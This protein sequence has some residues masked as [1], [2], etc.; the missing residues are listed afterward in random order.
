MA[1]HILLVT[2]ACLLACASTHGM[3]TKR[4]LKLH[5]SFFK[6][7]KLGRKLPAWRPGD[8]NDL[9]ARFQYHYEARCFKPK[10][11]KLNNEIEVAMKTGTDR[12][13]SK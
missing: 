9:C 7:V 10:K 12:L 4:L 5:R 6:S 11:V 1:K 2:F 8:E 13:Q 3:L